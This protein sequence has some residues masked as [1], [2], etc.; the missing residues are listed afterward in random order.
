MSHKIPEGFPTWIS[1]YDYLE[2]EHPDYLKQR[3]IWFVTHYPDRNNDDTK[4]YK[5]KKYKMSI[6]MLKRLCWDELQEYRLDMEEIHQ[7]VILNH[8]QYPAISQKFQ[9][10]MKISAKLSNII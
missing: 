9:K 7:L 10:F 2:K 1:F 6:A 4:L 5:V 8:E 3:S